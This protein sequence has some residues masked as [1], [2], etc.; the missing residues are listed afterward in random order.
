MNTNININTN[1][2]HTNNT[3]T[4][5]IYANYQKAIQTKLTKNLLDLIVLQLINQQAM[6]GYQIITKTHQIFGA[7]FG[8]ST[9]YPLLTKLEKKGYLHSN[10]NMN[11]EKPC[12]VFTIT[13]TG[14]NI[15]TYT[16]NS[17]N[18]ICKTIQKTENTQPT[19]PYTY[20]H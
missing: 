13:T 11:A 12:K 1:K 3:K 6:H 17:L 20:I 14:K 18:N 2:T 15:I 7:N 5:N 4:K 19:T 9:I 16:E 8:P 10:W